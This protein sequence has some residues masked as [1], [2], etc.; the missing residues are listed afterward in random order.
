MAQVMHK[1]S[2]II[3]KNQRLSTQ[4]KTQDIFQ[5]LSKRSTEQTQVTTVSTPLP[6][7]QKPV[8]SNQWNPKHSSASAS[9]HCATALCFHFERNS[10]PCDLD[11]SGR[12][13]HDFS[14]SWL[15]RCVNTPVVQYFG[16]TEWYRRNQ[17]KAWRI[18]R[19]ALTVALLSPKFNFTLLLEPSALSHPRRQSTHG[20]SLKPYGRM[21]KI[22]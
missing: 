2:T 17:H 11:E 9:E 4:R 18:C 21:K 20:I 14:S 6:L 12:C 1:T 19:S 5:P 3:T 16:S 22:P 10:K 15:Q 13:F 7:E 8:G